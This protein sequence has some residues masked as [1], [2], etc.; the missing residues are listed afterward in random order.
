MNEIQT[1]SIG[2]LILNKETPLRP[3]RVEHYLI[4]SYQRGYRWTELHVLALLEDI[5]AF[6]KKQSVGATIQSYCLQPIVG[7]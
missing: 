2:Q 7:Q 3:Q 6:L 5:D 1:T 4:P